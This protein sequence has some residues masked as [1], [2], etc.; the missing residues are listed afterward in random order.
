MIVYCRN[1]V[2]DITVLLDHDDLRKDKDLI[3]YERVA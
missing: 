3:K 2:G 1:H